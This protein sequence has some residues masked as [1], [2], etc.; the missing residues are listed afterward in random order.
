MITYHVDGYTQCRTHC[1]SV[2]TLM[3]IMLPIGALE[4]NISTRNQTNY[5]IKLV[6]LLILYTHTYLYLI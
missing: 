4:N 1:H 6:R 2:P 3:L 5:Q